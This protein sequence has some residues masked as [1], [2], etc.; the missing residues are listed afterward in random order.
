MSEAL[1][2]GNREKALRLVYD[3]VLDVGRQ[4][5]VATAD[6]HRLDQSAAL[7]T[8]LPIYVGEVLEK[9]LSPLE[10]HGR[11]LRPDDGISQMTAFVLASSALLDPLQILVDLMTGA[12]RRMSENRVRVLA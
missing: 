7:P 5:A 11:N 2:A 1:A 10:I 12:V 4:L 9:L 6:G 3:G 8:N